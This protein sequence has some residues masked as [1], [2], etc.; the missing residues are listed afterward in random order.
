MVPPAAVGGS[1]A[2]ETASSPTRGMPMPSPLDRVGVAENPV[3]APGDQMRRARE[4]FTSAA[5]AHIVFARLGRGDLPN[6]PFAVAG[7]FNPR[8]AREHSID[9]ELLRFRFRAA[10]RAPGFSRNALRTRAVGT[11]HLPILPQDPNRTGIA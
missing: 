4:D 11:R 1:T 10:G 9:V 8:R 7:T 6:H 3:L 2:P 5:W